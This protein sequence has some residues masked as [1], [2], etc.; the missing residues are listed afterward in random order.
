MIIDIYK[1]Y[2]FNYL[3]MLF[4][5]RLLDTCRT[6]INWLDITEM[7]NIDDKYK[8]QLTQP[9]IDRDINPEKLDA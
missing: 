9:I 4:K 7:H 2:V 5:I 6:S 1:L 8:E 3:D